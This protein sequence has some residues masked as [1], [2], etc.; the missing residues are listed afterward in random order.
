MNTVGAFEAKTHLA[1]L[2]ERV[3]KGERF[4]I[5]R[6]G[7][8]IAQLVPVDHRDPEKMRRAIE[9]LGAFSQDKT[10]QVGWKQARDAGRKW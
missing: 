5:T 10:L 1:A 3:A 8:A 9:R 7:T 4:T 2:L 6:H